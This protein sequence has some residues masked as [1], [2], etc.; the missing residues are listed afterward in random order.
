MLLQGD[1]ADNELR[2]FPDELALTTKLKPIEYNLI[3]LF[4]N[5]RDPFGDPFVRTTL[6]HREE[7]T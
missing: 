1:L 3:R 6:D 5:P 7:L 4:G 2:G